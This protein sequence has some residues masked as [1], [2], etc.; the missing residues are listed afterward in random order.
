[1]IQEVEREKPVITCEDCGNSFSRERIRL[2]LEQEVE[3]T[4][5]EEAED[6]GPFANGG[7]CFLEGQ[8]RF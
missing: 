7:F 5:R 6:I 2:T 8:N 3:G 4:S 1:M